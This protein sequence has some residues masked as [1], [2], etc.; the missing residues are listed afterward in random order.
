MRRTRAWTTLITA[1]AVL[2]LGAAAGAQDLSFN[3]QQ[4]KAT[5]AD[6][7][8]Y[9]NINEA[10]QMGAAFGN[11]ANGSHGTFGKFPADF[12][13]PFHVHTFAYHGIVIA[14]E[15]TNPFEGADATPR[16]GPG[17]YW[18]V[19]AGAVHA[20]A[21]VSDTPCQFFFTSAGAFDF[22]VHEK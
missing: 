2:L 16:L 11:M 15:M 1:A 14:G 9:Q 18:Y 4:P 6:A 7:I 13:T 20:T 22:T 10:I 17:S 8:V 19:P 21:C 12:I 5:P 3:P